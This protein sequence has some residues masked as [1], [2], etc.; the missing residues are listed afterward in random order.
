MAKL[1]ELFL[2]NKLWAEGKLRADPKYFKEMS[3]SQTPRYLWIGCSDSRVPANEITGTNPGDM[4]VHRNIANLVVHN[5]LNLMSVIQ[6]AI[7][8]LKVDHI[9]VCGHTLCGGVHASLGH[10]DLGMINKWLNSVRNVALQHRDELNACEDN[11]AKVNRLVE[12]N[13]MEQARN[14][15]RLHSIQKSWKQRQ[16]PTVHAWLYDLKT[17]R[18]KELLTLEPGTYKVEPEFEYEV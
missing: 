1:P 6:Y 4:F 7:E 13:A 12:L 10:S 15:V 14:L 18:L 11:E 5:D 8:Q 17:G 3:E 9:I 16:A 2:E